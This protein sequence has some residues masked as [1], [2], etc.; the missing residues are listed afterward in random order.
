MNVEEMRGGPPERYQDHNFYDD[1]IRDNFGE[2]GLHALL[3]LAAEQ[4]ANFAR[5][6]GPRRKKAAG[7][8]IEMLLE[9]VGLMAGR[10]ALA[11]AFASEE[12]SP[13]RRS[14]VL[15]A[16]LPR[17]LLANALFKK[18]ETPG[19]PA[20]LNVLI[21]EMLAVANGDAPRLMARIDGREGSFTNK[22]RSSLHRLRA[23]QWDRALEAWGVA[24]G[25]RHGEIGA[26][27][28]AE[29]TRIRNWGEQAADALGPELVA[30]M[31]DWAAAG[32]DPV[33]SNPLIREGY[34]P[35]LERDGRAFLDE[36]AARSPPAPRR[37]R[38]SSAKLSR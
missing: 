26:A 38:K 37:P 14:S 12:P 9:A 22:Y 31:L 30:T 1:L 7:R 16:M 34:K 15:N 4:K 2:V 10:E 23:L 33:F 3:Q 24:P 25:I 8:L 28:G 13:D 5:T 21:W 35:F 11:A 20:S 6:S 18:V 27:Y 32:L 19:D 17:L 29:W 36:E